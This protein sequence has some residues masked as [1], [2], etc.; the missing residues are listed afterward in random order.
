MTIS[1]KL[2]DFYENLEVTRIC[3]DEQ[4]CLNNEDRFT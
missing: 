4:N 2:S 1:K 3:Y